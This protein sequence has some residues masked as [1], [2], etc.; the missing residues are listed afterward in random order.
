LSTAIT[1][2]TVSH[3]PACT[4]ARITYAFAKKPAV[5]GI[6]V[7]DSRNSTIR[8]PSAGSRRPRP[9]NVSS[10]LLTPGRFCSAA[11]TANAP[12]FMNAYAAP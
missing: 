8:I 7:S 1:A 11:M 5:G 4:A 9:A 2:R 10:R 12:R 6:P 3:P